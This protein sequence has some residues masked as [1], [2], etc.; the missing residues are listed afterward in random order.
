MDR[1]ASLSLAR[2]LPRLEAEFAATASPADWESFTNRLAD[3][4]AT[5]FD[6]LVRLYG[7]QYDFF[8][9]LERIV[10]LAAR[11]WLDRPADLKALD[12]RREADP[13]WFTAG[14]M[15]GGFCY[16]DRF[17][18]DLAGLRDKLPYIREL[19]LTYLHLM[20]LF[21]APAGNSDGGY[22]VSSYREVDPRLG[23][24][25]DLAALAGELR[26]SGISLVLD[27]VFNHTADE[28]TWARRAQAG[29]P[30][31]LDYYLTFPDRTLPDAY[32]QTL[33]EIFPEQRPGSF[34][35]RPDMGRWVWTTF[36]SFQWDL[37]YANPEVFRSMAAEML[38]LANQ[39]VEV[40]RLDAVV[41]CWK[42]LGTSCENLPESHLLVRAFNAL[43][44]IAAPALLFKSEA[45]VHPDEVR[46]F[47][48]PRECQT[49]YNPLL[50]AL[51]WDALATREVAL[52]ATSLR[53][54]V[55]LDPR[56]AWVNYVRS[57]DDIGWTFDDGDAARLG[58]DPFGHRR[59]LNDFYTG[60]FPGSFARGLPFQENPR[61]G[62]ARVTG[63]TASLAGLE[64]ALLADDPRAIDLAI[65]RILL[66]YGLTILFGGI[67]LLSLGDELGQR[68]D[69]RYRLDPAQAD[70]SRWVGR[71]RLDWHAAARRDDPT[72]IEGRLYAGFRRLIAIRRS[73]AAFG[74]ALTEIID[75]GNGHVFGY[76]RQGGDGRALV[77]ANVTERSQTLD[78]NLLRLHGLAYRLVD[79]LGGGVITA[80]APCTLAPY[81]LLCLM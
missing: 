65:G 59:F 16:V 49:S 22:A 6:C 72:T 46:Q 14:R 4:F 56:C 55:R 58:T 53:D 23:T 27:F 40:L 28:H 45:I 1:R 69:Y 7:D 80:T 74:G 48:S 43:A 36:N 57:H 78:G 2:L 51:L 37:N 70:D 15:L 67:P 60:R 42:R 61:T 10:A 77:L 17:A 34:T 33:R 30:D 76:I 12:A 18:G 81:Q 38:F 75:T 39:G 54:R 50:M 5:L 47:I 79:L 66:L 31:Y 26:A 8:Y 20:P 52:L 73:H 24:M 62:D 21:L 64:A 63:T 11:Q 19:G 41:F 29:D 68:N 44:R 25:A 9:H 71:P 32:E 13:A 3:N 35:Y